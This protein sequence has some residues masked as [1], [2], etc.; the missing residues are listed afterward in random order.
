MKRSILFW[1]VV[2][3]PLF[4]FTQEN[5][6]YLPIELPSNRHGAIFAV[7][8][9]IVH[10]VSDGGI[11]YK[12]E[13]GG[14]RWTEFDGGIAESFFDLAFDSPDL[15]YAA[16]ENGSILK[17]SDAGQ[18]WT[19]LPSNT[20]NNLF[21]VGINSSSSVWIV[22]DNGTVLH[23]TDSGNSWEPIDISTS[24]RLNSIRFK[25]DQE[26]FI[27]GNSGKLYY[28]QNGGV[29]W[30]QLIIPT[31]LDLFSIS[32]IGDYIYLLAGQVS[33][34]SG[35]NTYSGMDILKSN[36]NINWDSHE[37][38]ILEHGPA[39]IFFTQ[40]NIG[41]SINSAALL[42]DCCYVEIKKTVDGGETWEFSLNEETDA[43][44]C[45]AN[46][47][48][49]DIEFAS[50][51]VGYILLGEGILKTPYDSTA[52]IRDIKSEQSFLIYPN[53]SSK[54]Q[55]SVK[56]NSFELDGLSMEIIDINGKI[57]YQL[58]TLKQDNVL[59]V[60][61]LSNGVYFVNLLKNGKI[62]NSQKLMDRL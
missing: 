22:G 39:D 58:D 21:S 57:L 37:L 6:D 61:T 42:C 54:G 15:G 9:D 33:A 2:L 16:G 7:N 8:E 59:N 51:Q 45:H 30:S 17:S 10:A 50:E 47:G 48:Y 38:D 41:Y 12:T 62:I 44:S 5:W 25:N 32:L 1:A 31:T 56:I 13:D 53:R 35:E 36:N 55:F 29:T 60:P 23:S 3:S 49:A 20:V 34:F 14:L 18:T 26:G 52:S 43:A 24:D 40:E 19:S 27:A 4:S 11:F 46:S 28:T